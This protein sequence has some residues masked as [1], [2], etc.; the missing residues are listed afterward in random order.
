MDPRTFMTQT[1]DVERR[2]QRT[3]GRDQIEKARREAER[4]QQMRITA[5]QTE[6]AEL[7]ERLDTIKSK[8]T[9]SP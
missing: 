5:K 3:E 2:K 7:T 6:W 9:V 1:Q 4:K 8:R